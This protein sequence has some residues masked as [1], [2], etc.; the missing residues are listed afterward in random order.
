MEKFCC[1]IPDR[2]DRKELTDFCLKQLSRMTVKPDKIYHINHRPETE[3]FDLTSRIH[4]GVSIAKAEGFDW[5][6]VIENDDYYPADYFLR[7]QPFMDKYD[8]LGEE[9]SIYF[10]LQNLTYKTIDHNF[11]SSLFTTAFRVSAL[12]NFD[13]PASTHVFLDIDLWKY[14]RFRKRMFIKT[15]AIGIK[16]GLGLCGGKGH[17]MH[18]QNFDQNLKWLEDHTD[19]MAFEFYTGLVEQLKKIHA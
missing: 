4:K 11:R 3:R 8:F 17:T 15:G 16:H 7:F 5:C 18:M 13:W 1:I 19:D 12:N 14:A 9:K 10:N 2:G 6:F